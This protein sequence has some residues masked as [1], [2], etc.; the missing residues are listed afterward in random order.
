MWKT[1][2]E[3]YATHIWNLSRHERH[4][5]IMLALCATPYLQSFHTIWLPLSWKG[6]QKKKPRDRN[7]SVLWISTK[8][9]PRQFQTRASDGFT[10]QWLLAIL[11][12]LPRS[13]FIFQW[14]DWG[15]EE[16]DQRLK[17]SKLVVG[18]AE[19]WGHV[20]GKLGNMNRIIWDVSKCM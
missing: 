5:Y 7:W 19:I 1:P 10:R 14:I 8:K 15:W 12:I 2:V 16:R 13:P 4:D 6:T 9:P 20:G 3:V 18:Q 11:Q 17:G